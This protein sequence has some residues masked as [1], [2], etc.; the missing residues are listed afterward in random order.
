[1]F[2]ENLF[3]IIFYDPICNI[4]T[5]VFNSGLLI[6]SFAKSF[7]VFKSEIDLLIVIATLESV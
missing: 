7:S 3:S 1:M 5:E 2:C 6:Q 4:Q